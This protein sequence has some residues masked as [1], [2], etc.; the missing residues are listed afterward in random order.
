MW[1]NWRHVSEWFFIHLLKN[2]KQCLFRVQITISSNRKLK[3]FNL[4]QGE[5]RL[6]IGHEQLYLMYTHP[7][8]HNTHTPTHTLHA[9]FS[10]AHMRDFQKLT[11]VKFKPP[12]ARKSN[13]GRRKKI[14]NA[15]N[16]NAS[17][18]SARIQSGDTRKRS[19]F[20]FSCLGSSGGLVA[21]FRLQYVFVEIR[22]NYP[23]MQ[24]LYKGMYK[25]SIIFEKVPFILSFIFLLDPLL[26][27]TLWLVHF[28]NFLIK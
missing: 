25:V 1:K 16:S 11:C 3:C 19:L 4:F 13:A 27:L 5:L 28:L 2:L 20:L 7:N 9:W 26:A 24:E 10:K 12:N 23:G 17:A 14:A 18:D 6:I 8:T 15:W 22:L 21:L